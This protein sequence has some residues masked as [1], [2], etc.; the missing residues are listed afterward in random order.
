MYS[1]M[2]KDKDC[3]YKVVAIKKQKKVQGLEGIEFSLLR[4]I[5]LLQ[6]LDHPNVV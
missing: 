6:Q 4:E 1:Q 2:E 3:E 5:K